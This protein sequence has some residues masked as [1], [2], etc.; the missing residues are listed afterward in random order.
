MSRYEWEIEDE[1]VEYFFGLSDTRE[2]YQQVRFRDGSRADLIVEAVLPEEG[3][4]HLY[5]VVEVKAI[6]AGEKALRQLHGYLSH[7][8][9]VLRLEGNDNYMVAGMLAAPSFTPSIESYA[10]RCA[11]DDTP[12]S[13]L[14]VVE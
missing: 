12:F 11:W 5:T 3:E 4:P 8:R 7:V 6:R 10:N 14:R 9:A 13:I 2:V 1:L